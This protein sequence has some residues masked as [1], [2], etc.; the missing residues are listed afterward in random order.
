MEKAASRTWEA[1]RAQS[2]D[3]LLPV[4]SQLLDVAAASGEIR[5]L[6]TVSFSGFGA[7]PEEPPVSR[8]TRPLGR[9]TT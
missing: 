3:R 1:E 4:C 9:N 8:H 5:N 7:D 6:M 2:L